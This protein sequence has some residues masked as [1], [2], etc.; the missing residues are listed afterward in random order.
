V[1]CA[2]AAAVAIGGTVLGVRS[3]YRGVLRSAPGLGVAVVSAVLANGAMSVYGLLLTV[4]ATV[5]FRRGRQL[6]RFGRVLFP[7]SRPQTTGPT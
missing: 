3:L 5:G 2:A 1:V 7:A 4:F 6:R